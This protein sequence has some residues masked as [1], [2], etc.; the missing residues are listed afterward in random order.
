[1]L[2]GFDGQLYETLIGLCYQSPGKMPE[3]GSDLEEIYAFEIDGEVLFKQYFAV[4][5]IFRELQPYYNGEEY[6]FEVPSDDLGALR[7]QLN[8]YGYDLRVVADAEIESFCVVKEQYTKHADI[9]RNS[10]AHWSR[11]GYNFFLM[12]DPLAVD[13]ALE[14]GAQRVGETNLVAGL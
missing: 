6:R 4:K 12:K 3:F 9:L 14:Q 8:E 5:S 1:M 11:D 13:Q 7:D 2:F 10:V